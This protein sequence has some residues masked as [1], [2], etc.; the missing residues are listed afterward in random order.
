MNEE[1]KQQHLC[2]QQAGTIYLMSGT[3]YQQVFART[4]NSPTC[5]VPAVVSETKAEQLYRQLHVPELKEGV[6]GIRR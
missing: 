5:S 6:A 2:R 3:T 1:K 4:V